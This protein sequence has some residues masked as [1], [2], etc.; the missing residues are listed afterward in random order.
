L[1]KNYR[2]DYV[3]KV[4]QKDGSRLYLSAEDVKNPS[5]KLKGTTLYLYGKPV[6]QDVSRVQ[7]L[8]WN[9]YTWKRVR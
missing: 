6:A 9:R 7:M 8:E 3:L 2:Y 1:T 5:P 4:Y